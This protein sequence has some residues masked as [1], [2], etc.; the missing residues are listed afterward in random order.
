MR[1]AT[2]ALFGA[3]LVIAGFAA[4]PAN[5][6]MTASA[7]AAMDQPEMTLPAICTASASEASSTMN[8]MQ[9]GMGMDDAHT[10]LMAGMGGM[11][12]NMM[13][14]ATAKNI[15]VA[16]VCSMIPH[17]MGAIAMAKAELKYGKDAWTKK[18][19]QLIIDAQEKEISEMTAWLAKQSK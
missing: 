1:S 4:G 6:A 16:F 12:K 19:A 9:D 18:K 8:S 3:T 11:N 17:H 7:M 15:D 14:G 10:A 2:T 13:A 5:A